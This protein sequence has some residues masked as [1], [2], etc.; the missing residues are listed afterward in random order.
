MVFI[1]IQ[2]W[3]WKKG[4]LTRRWKTRKDFSQIIFIINGTVIVILIILHLK[5]CMLDLRYPDNR[6]LV[7]NL[8]YIAVFLVWKMFYSDNFLFVFAASC[9]FHFWKK[10]KISYIHTAFKGT[11]VNQKFHCINENTCT[12]PLN[13]YF[14]ICILLFLLQTWKA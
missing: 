6:Y 12:V 14:S 2:N 4:N 10:K 11:V 8:E 3:I 7:D 1:I 9:A 5:R 13:N